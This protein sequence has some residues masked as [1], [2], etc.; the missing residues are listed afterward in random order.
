[1]P[2]AAV[3]LRRCAAVLADL[4]TVGGVQVDRCERSVARRRLCERLIV[5]VINTISDLL[6]LRRS[7]VVSVKV[8]GTWYTHTSRQLCDA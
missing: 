6:G 8:N 4:E 5:V 1:M 2:S 7:V 3:M